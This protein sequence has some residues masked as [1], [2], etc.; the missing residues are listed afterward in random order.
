MRFW[1]SVPSG[2]LAWKTSRT[3]EPGGLQFTGLQ[4]FGCSWVSTQ[5]D[6]D[7]ASH[8]VQGQEPPTSA[9]DLGL[10]PG[11]GR[12]PGEGSG[13]PLQY[14]C[15][16]NHMDRRTWWVTVCGVAKELDITWGLNNNTKDIETFLNISQ[17]L[18]SLWSHRSPGSQWSHHLSNIA[19]CP[20]KAKQPCD[21]VLP[22]TVKG[23]SSEVINICASCL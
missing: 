19:N 14:S 16:G 23:Y 18:Y 11:S 8:V 20:P 7:E 13:N 9:G 17:W 12:A 1:S 3:E 10:I 4:R 5:H 2:V 22:K 6:R 15:L 21:V